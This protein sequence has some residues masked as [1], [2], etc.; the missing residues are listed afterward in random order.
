MYLMHSVCT[1]YFGQTHCSMDGPYTVATI[2]RVLYIFITYCISERLI[3]YYLSEQL[4]CIFLFVHNP[5]LVIVGAD[6]GP[7]RGEFRV[8]LQEHLRP[9]LPHHQDHVDS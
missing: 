4:E 5:V 7:G 3:V 1:D 2:L 8:Y 6:C 9:P